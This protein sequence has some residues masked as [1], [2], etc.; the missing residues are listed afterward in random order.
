MAESDV[1]TAV[2]IVDASSSKDS[3]TAVVVTVVATGAVSMR[4]PF[5][6]TAPPISAP[7]HDPSE[8][9]DV[10]SSTSVT[11]PVP[12]LDP[13]SIDPTPVA[14]TLSRLEWS[15][16]CASLAKGPGRDSWSASKAEAGAPEWAD[17]SM[18]NVVSSEAAKPSFVAVL[19]DDPGWGRCMA[20]VGPRQRGGGRE[21]REENCGGYGGQDEQCRTRDEHGLDA[22]G[23]A[24]F[25]EQ[26]IF[27]STTTL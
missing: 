7:N 9:A 21:R 18:T 24:G 1:V 10:A 3:G 20:S 27:T 16:A 22:R 13:V 25:D 11:D 17:D 19:I 5:S 23:R 8:S 26:A 4:S 6:A 12:V 14:D 2:C 15:A